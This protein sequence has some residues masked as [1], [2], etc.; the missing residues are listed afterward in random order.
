MLAWGLDE[1]NCLFLI[2]REKT[3]YCCFTQRWCSKISPRA[4]KSSS[5]S[6]DVFK[7]QTR[8]GNLCAHWVLRYT[9]RVQS[10]TTWWMTSNSLYPPA[11]LP[12]CSNISFISCKVNRLI[13]QRNRCVYVKG[14]RLKARKI[15]VKH[16]NAFG[17]MC[18]DLPWQ[19]LI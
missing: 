18:W 4:Q 13:L 7:P 16:Q 8:N 1:C 12:W 15:C 17:N 9:K 6:A 2:L 3:I 14:G 11:Q 19:M 5:A 10:K